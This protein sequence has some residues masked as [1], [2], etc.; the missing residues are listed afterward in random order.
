MEKKIESNLHEL[1]EKQRER[2]DTSFMDSFVNYM[3]D[4][5]RKAINKAIYDKAEELKV[6]VYDICFMF[7]PVVD[8]FPEMVNGTCT[9]KMTISWKPIEEYDKQGK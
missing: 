1:I 2:I 4:E 7:V 8:R 6:S 5:E 3:R 9:M